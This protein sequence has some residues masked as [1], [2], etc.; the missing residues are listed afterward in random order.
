MLCSLSP[1]SASHLRRA[2]PM[3]HKEDTHTGQFGKGAVSGPLQWQFSFPC[4]RIDW[5]SLLCRWHR[6]I[7]PVRILHPLLE[8]PSHSGQPSGNSSLSLVF[9]SSLFSLGFLFH[10]PEYLGR[11]E[12]ASK[13]HCVFQELACSEFWEELNCKHSI[14][15]SFLKREMLVN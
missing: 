9:V 13:Q 3:F 7:R 10:K 4:F 6:T 1:S 15:A 14:F 5:R 8:D 2:G 12:Q 11:C